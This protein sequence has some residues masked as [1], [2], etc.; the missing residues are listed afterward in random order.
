MDEPPV[1]DPCEIIPTCPICLSA[2]LKL[3]RRMKDMDICLCEHCGTSLTV[4][5]DAWRIRHGGKPT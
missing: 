4:P 5:H 2:P 1:P 3:A